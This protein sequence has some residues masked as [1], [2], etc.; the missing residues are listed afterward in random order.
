M[1]LPPMLPTRKYSGPAPVDIWEVCWCFVT[2]C[3]QSCCLL[4]F[5]CLGSERHM[6]LTLL[7]TNHVV[8]K[9][10]TFFS[11]NI[12]KWCVYSL[13][14]SSEKSSSFRKKVKFSMLNICCLSERTHDEFEK[15]NIDVQF[16]RRKKYI[17]GVKGALVWVSFGNYWKLF[18]IMSEHKSATRL[19]VFRHFFLQE[20]DSNTVS[21]I[22][23]HMWECLPA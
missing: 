10:G 9:R 17:P 7:S 11:H 14:E 1:L 21:Q 16:T 23:T 12:I 4:V 8:W 3:P 22:D 13:G 2:H 20:C 6:L 19:V 5:V 15:K 18:W